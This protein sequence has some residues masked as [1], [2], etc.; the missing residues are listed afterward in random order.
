MELCDQSLETWICNRNKQIPNFQKEVSHVRDAKLKF[1]GIISGLE[2]IHSR[3]IIHRDLKPANILISPRSVIKIADFGISKDNPDDNHTQ[4]QG[5][6]VYR[7][8]EQI[9]SHY[10]T[11]V[12]IYASGKSYP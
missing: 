5:T 11:E 12:D 10:G 6:R 9:Y 4:N 2:Y 1:Y 7:P 3:N 8:V